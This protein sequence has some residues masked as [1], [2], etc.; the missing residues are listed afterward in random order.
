[1]ILELFKSIEKESKEL[2]A[3]LDAMVKEKNNEA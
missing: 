1:M 2:F 3:T